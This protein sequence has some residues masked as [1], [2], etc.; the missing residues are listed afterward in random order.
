MK[1]N[2]ISC[3]VLLFKQHAHRFK[4]KGIRSDAPMVALLLHLD[5]QMPQRFA[6]ILCH[7]LIDLDFVLSLLFRLFEKWRECM[8]EQDLPF[9]IRRHNGVCWET[10]IGDSQT[11]Q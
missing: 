11:F 6:V 4:V 3:L 2:R 10:K 5:P 1:S 8:P 9:V 7:N